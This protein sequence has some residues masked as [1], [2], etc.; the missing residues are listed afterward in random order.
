MVPP[1]TA[2][3]THAAPLK[4][5]PAGATSRLKHGV[6]LC[7]RNRP[8]TSVGRRTRPFPTKFYF[9]ANLPYDVSKM[10]FQSSL[11]Q[12]IYRFFVP[13]FHL[14]R[15]SPLLQMQFDIPCSSLAGTKSAS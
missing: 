10:L 1:V 5:L 13:A 4:K 14:E 7:R 11:S 6:E 8:K 15:Q 3:D 2:S 9:I 12:Q